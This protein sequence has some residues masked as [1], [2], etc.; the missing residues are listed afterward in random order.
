M[1]IQTIQNLKDFALGVTVAY[2][3]LVAFFVIA[4]VINY[5]RKHRD[6]G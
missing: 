5:D 2:G 1:D 4:V 3:F 6:V